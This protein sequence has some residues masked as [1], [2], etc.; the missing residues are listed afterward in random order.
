VPVGPGPGPGTWNLEPPERPGWVGK[1]GKVGTVPY[2]GY[3][4][5][6]EIG[7]GGGRGTCF[8]EHLD[9]RMAGA[10][11]ILVV[12]S[13]CVDK[14]TGGFQVPVSGD[15]GGPGQVRSGSL[16]SLLYLAISPSS[17]A[18]MTGV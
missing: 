5:G 6:E 7:R 16:L 15:L 10:A 9:G 14:M 18:G 12:V 13:V 2:L 3:H 1:E 8:S 11:A 17:R 4:K